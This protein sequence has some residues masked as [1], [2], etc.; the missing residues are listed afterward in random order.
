MRIM[1]GLPVVWWQVGSAI[2]INLPYM[3]VYWLDIGCTMRVGGG[4]SRK[5]KKVS[6]LPSRFMNTVI[7][8]NPTNTQIIVNMLVDATVPVLIMWQYS[9]ACCSYCGQQKRRAN[10]E[11]YWNSIWWKMHNHAEL[12]NTD[13]PTSTVSEWTH[14]CQQV[15]SSH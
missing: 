10:V 11:C 12:Q 2:I 7:T 14:L 3:S 4:L 13:E 6:A 15:T 1:V 5:S 9:S 8:T